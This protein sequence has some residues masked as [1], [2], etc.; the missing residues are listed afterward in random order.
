M[1]IEPGLSLKNIADWLHAEFVGD[2]DHLV[3]GINEIHKV[4]VGD[5]T[6]VDFDKYYDKALLSN[7]STI[8]INKKVTCPPGK[9]LIYSVDPFRDYVALVK[10]FRPFEPAKK[11]ISRTAVI[12]MDTI[13]QPNVFIGNHVTIGNNCIIHANV[14]IYDHTI[15]GDNVI[16]HS[17][18]VIGADAYYFKRRHE[19]HDK[20]ESCGRVIIGDNVEIGALTSIDK[21]VSGDTIIGSGTKFDNHVQVGHD[22]IIGKNVLVGAFCAIAGVTEIQDDVVLWANVMINKDIVIGKGAIILADS[23]VDKTLPGGKKY[24]GA[25]VDDARK[26]WREIALMRKLPEMWEKIKGL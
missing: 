6:F 21:G 25:P 23:G 11:M 10:K 22:T 15:I 3:T 4:E 18:S 26:K 24:W 7:A 16:I 8:I 5:I 14:S 12:G 19:G 1:K 20:M 9:T 17:N 2:P 13:I